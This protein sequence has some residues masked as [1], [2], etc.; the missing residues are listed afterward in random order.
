MS[1]ELPIIAL[2]GPTASGKT[3]LAIELAQKLPIELISVDSALVYRGLDIGSGKPSLA[4]QALAPHRLIDI[5]DPADAYSAARFAEDA[6][7]HISEVRANGN[8]PLLVGGT[9][10]YFRALLDGMADMPKADESLRQKLSEEAAEKGWAAMHEHL[11]VIDPE[12]AGRLH[13][14]DAQ[15]IQ[16]ALEVFEL[17]GKPLS[18]WHADQ[19][20]HDSSQ[21]RAYRFVY[22]PEDRAMLHRNIERRFDQMLA[23][24]FVTEVEALYQRGD[25]DESMPSIRSVGYRQVWQHVEGHCDLAEARERGIIATRQLAKRQMTWLRNQLPD[26]PR[27]DAGQQAGR[28]QAFNEIAALIA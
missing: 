10:L 20:R 19:R 14:N 7:F 27:F 17:T 28:Q 25:L 12:T 3:A 18:Q 21:K 22:G 6:R 8:V 16:R 1:T 15:R 13:P 26:V 2:M 9:F 4:E 23:A 11:A 5:C 24:G